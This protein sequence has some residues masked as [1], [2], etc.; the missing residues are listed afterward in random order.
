MWGTRAICGSYVITIYIQ[1]QTTYQN[2]RIIETTWRKANIL[3]LS[4][5]ILKRESTT[6]ELQEECEVNYCILSKIPIIV[7]SSTFMKDMISSFNGI[8]ITWTL[9]FFMRKESKLIFSCENM[10]DDGSWGS[11]AKWIWITEIF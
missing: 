11:S 10:I 6:V 4:N 1:I 5:T 2:K 3:Q 8:M 9:K 7:K